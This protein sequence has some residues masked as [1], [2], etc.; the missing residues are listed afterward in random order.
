M[1]TRHLNLGG[2]IFSRE[3]PDD[4][5]PGV[6]LPDW[7][8]PGVSFDVTYAGDNNPNNALYHVRGIVDGLA[9]CRR[10]QSA[11]QR[12]QYDV[13]DPIYFEVTG[14]HIRRREEK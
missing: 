8:K 1:A 13:L 6:A 2:M 11:K 9:V 3:E 4:P 10:W 12:W 14:D 5:K 7:V